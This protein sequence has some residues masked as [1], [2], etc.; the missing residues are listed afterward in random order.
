MIRV[1]A[2]RT[3]SLNL[4][5]GNTEFPTD[6]LRSEDIAAKA[7]D[8]DTALGSWSQS[9]PEDW[10]FSI[11]PSPAT[12][13]ERDNSYNDAVHEYPTH[14]HA[15]VW[16]RYRAVRLIVNSIL[17]R[18]LAHQLQSLEYS[19]QRS[20]VVIQ[21]ETVRASMQLIINELCAGVPFFFNSLDPT[22]L[23]SIK[24]GKYSFTTD[25]E[26][27]P[28]MAALLAWPLTVAVSTEYIPEAERQW[29][30]GRLKTV[31]KSLGD[32]VLECVVEQ[33]EFRF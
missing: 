21:Q 15:A 22:G 2:L 5:L 8:L 25:D 13:G 3:E 7:Q 33:G 28:K 20:F 29:L 24:L 11:R 32:A 14:G 30:K 12:P 19:S 4:L 26:I 31:A 9:L 1:A 18:C 23:R 17:I 10:I 6:T 16:N 27:F